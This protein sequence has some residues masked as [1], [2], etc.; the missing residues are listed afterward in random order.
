[1]DAVLE[2][3]V[4]WNIHSHGER[5]ESKEAANTLYELLLV[6]EYTEAVAQL[7]PQFFLAFIIQI[8]HVLELGLVG[9]RVLLAVEPTIHSDLSPWRTALEALRSLLSTRACWQSFM[10]MELQDSWQLFSTLDTF[11]EAVSLL[12]R[13]VCVSL[14]QN[15]CPMVPE[16]L[17]T[18]ASS[19]VGKGPQGGSVAVGLLAETVLDPEGMQLILQDGLE[20][21]DPV[22]RVISLQ[23]L[24]SLPLNTDKR[25]ILLAQLPFLLEGF[26][27]QDQEGVLASMDA[28][29][30]TVRSLGSRGLGHLRE[31]IVLM[32]GPFFDD[33]RSQVRVSALD[34]LAA[35][36]GSW[37]AEDKTCCQQEL[38]RCLIP[39]L[40]H[41][42]DEHPSVRRKAR[43]TF[44][45]LA[46]NVGWRF[47]QVVGRTL[48]GEER[49]STAYA[50]IWQAL[51]E[52]F[53]QSHPIFWSQALGIY[54][55]PPAR[56]EICSR[57]PP[58]THHH[59]HPQKPA[60]LRG[61]LGYLLQYNSHPKKRPLGQ[62]PPIPEVSREEP[63]RE[64]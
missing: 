17:Q 6:V 56:C 47:S 43:Y 32:L 61:R 12:A 64:R 29:T 57:C 34:L 30:L 26:Y 44:F 63:A 49:E 59:H 23:A 37:V 7:L 27:R 9:E 55:L 39:V 3:S 5:L 31:D 53:E 4:A 13:C 15:R 28:V 42:K 54:E 8:Q 35:V 46:Q 11:Q 20:D 14:V 45:W 36:A 48:I 51:M 33:E 24:T 21:P 60:V 2:P 10:S 38:I 40:F 25:S 62:D 18:V 16:L 52:S 41:L 58:H 1:M 19:L 50:T 22:L